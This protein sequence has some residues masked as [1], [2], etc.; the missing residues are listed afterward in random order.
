M[1][2]Y[3]VVVDGQVINYQVTNTPLTD[4]LLV[5]MTEAEYNADVAALLAQAEEEEDAAAEQTKDEQ[6]AALEQE[7][8]ALLFQLLTGENYESI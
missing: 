4:D 6:I 3:K 5:E 2:Y 7:N 1:Y 8:A